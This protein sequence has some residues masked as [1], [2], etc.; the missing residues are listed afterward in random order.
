MATGATT[1][2]ALPFPVST[3]PV[4]VSGDIQQLATQIDN[5]LQETIEDTASAQWTGG[6]F[7]NGL[8]APTYNDTTGKMSMS[9][10]Q[11]LQTS[12][13]PT[14]AGLTVGAVGSGKSITLGGAFS[15][16]GAFS[17]TLTVTGA[18]N[19]TLPTS[20]TL[21]NSAVATLGSLLNIASATGAITLQM[22]YGATTNGTTKAINIGPNGVSGSTT[23]IN[24]G[25]SVSGALGTTNIYSPTTYMAG[26]VGIA[27]TPSTPLHVAGTIRTE[28]IGLNTQY[29]E[30]YA[31][32]GSAVI[33]ASAGIPL[34]LGVNGNHLS[35]NTAGNVSVT[36]DIS[37]ATGKSYQ[38]NGVSVLNSTTLGS[39]VVSSSLTSVGTIA[40]GVWQGTAVAAAY[41]GTGQT[42][43]A[44]GDILYAST[45]SALSK[46]AG[47]ATGNALISGGV[48]TAP[49]WGKIGL[50]THI[51]GTLAVGNGGTGITSTPTNGQLLIGNGTNYTAAT[52]TQGT[53]MSI[54]NASGSIT[55]AVASVPNSQILKFD[56]GVTE[57]TDLYTFNGSAA[58]TIDIKAGT[59]ITLSKAAGAI[60]I[61]ASGVGT[62][63]N[64]MILK[65][66][67]GTTEGT[68]QYTFNGSASKTVNFVAGANIT[69]TET[70]GTVTIASTASGTGTVGLDSVMFLGGM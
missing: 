16:S 66:D 7:S 52:L 44:V 36:N 8:S 32:G 61:N 22:G 29:L 55:L 27:V 9:L 47:V 41:G 13:S 50:T 42:S 49:S 51:S 64:S 46:L 23:N 45:T 70:S 33:R 11:D 59:N 34:E 6:T 43:Y 19:V 39:S 56:T 54:T 62:T 28:R 14:F 17:T 57:G 15:T 35:I 3:D 21:V 31:S 69:L 38:V 68:D 4:N 2:Y 58:K 65:F 24:I 26:N 5:I 40:T 67:S 25:S 53:G 12:A 20:G 60:T 48:G 30:A 10:S 1:N 18:T 63:T 37:V